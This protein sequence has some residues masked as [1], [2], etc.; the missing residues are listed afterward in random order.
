MTGPIEDGLRGQS[1]MRIEFRLS[2]GDVDR[3]AG[4]V[5][6]LISSAG[7]PSACGIVWLDVEG[8]AAHIGVSVNA[9]RALVK[10]RE[11]PVHRTPNRRLRFSVTELDQWVR[12]DLAQST[13]EDLP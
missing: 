11:I 13:S 1:E 2:D 5:A 7:G 9:I 10:R 3:I 6:G 8:A 12:S 4:R